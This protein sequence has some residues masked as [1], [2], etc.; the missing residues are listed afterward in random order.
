MSTRAISMKK[1][2]E[3]LRL[4]VVS[5]LSNRQV[6]RALKISTGSVSHYMKA[7]HGANLDE[8][9]LDW[10]DDQLIKSLLPYCPQRMAAT[11]PAYIEPDF[12]TVYQELKQKGVTRHILWE[13]YKAAASSE[14]CF[15]YA[16]FCRRYRI[17]LKILKPSMRQI[18]HA[19]DKCFIDYCGPRIKI[20][21]KNDKEIAK[22]YIFVATLG[23]S[24][25]TFVT[26]S[27]TRSLPD[28]IAA[29]VATLNYFGGV[30][31]LMI[32]DNEK[33]GV[34]DACYYDPD[35][36]PTYADFARHYDTVIL[37]A[38][39]GCPKD[40][41]KVEKMVQVVETWIIAKLRHRKFYSVD[42]LNRAIAPLLEELNNKPF[43]KLPGSRRSQ[44]EAIDK[45]ALKALPHESYEYAKFKKITVGLDY[46]VTI[47]KHYY[48]VP[49]Q[50]IGKVVEARITQKS[51][52]LLLNGKMI[53]R[54]QRDDTPG[55][56]TTIEQHMPDAHRAHYQWTPASFQEFAKNIGPAMADVARQLIDS[57]KNP[58]CIYRIHNGYRTLAKRFGAQELEHAC[59]YALNHRAIRHGYIKDILISGLSTTNNSL[60]AAND[61]TSPLPQNHQHIRGS[62]HYQQSTVKK[63]LGET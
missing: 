51:I 27:L 15:S 21:G 54:H 12:A 44:F 25:Y 50:Y 42:E 46:H 47:N 28:W 13:E 49:Q 33:S 61:G 39:P 4:K 9:A 36:N 56:A 43:Q 1:L 59:C 62:G 31:N 10:D 16:E 5:G 57:Q 7:W 14:K 37:P 29:N 52:E 60:A 17:F 53:A 32:P 48:S 40:K 24:N 22:A 55:Q 35:V 26:A 58:E 38:R 20:Y 41:A 63:I 3:V 18:H 30:P 11:E 34:K 45:P 19:G 8:Q 6:A 23:A 2:K